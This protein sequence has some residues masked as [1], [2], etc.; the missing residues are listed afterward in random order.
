MWLIVGL[1][2]PGNS[3]RLTRHNV[4]FRVVERFA[5]VQGIQFKKRRWGAQIGEGRVGRQKV[6]VAKPLT[7]MNKSGVAVKKLIAELGVSLDHLVVVHDDLDL[8]CGRIKIK[9][10]G[11]HGGHKGVQSIIELLGS[12]GFLRVKVGIDKPRGHEEGADYVL[13]PFTAEERALVKE[14]V[15]QAV[16]AIEAIIV[17]GKDKAMNKYN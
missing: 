14:S 5:R 10:K 13:S 12:A 8:A 9:K 11:G 4:G 17:S 7:Y 15:E 3:Y 1:G 6:V 16:E 2:N